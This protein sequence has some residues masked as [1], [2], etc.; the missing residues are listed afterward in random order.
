MNIVVWQLDRQTG[1]VVQ[2]IGRFGPEGGAFSFLH[3]ATMDSKGNLYTG[4]VATGRRVQKFSPA[5]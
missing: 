3:V 5:Q 2:K 4:K 1:Q